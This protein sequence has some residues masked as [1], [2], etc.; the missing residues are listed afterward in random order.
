VPP[1]SCLENWVEAAVLNGERVCLEP[2]RV[3]HAEE[4]APVLE[5]PLLHIFLGGEPADRD[6]LRARYRRQVVGRSPDG[7]QRW[8][9]W[10]CAGARMHSRS[11]R[12]KPPSARTR[13]G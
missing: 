11:A 4:L 10:W 5:D 7:S 3:E 6:Q 12:S 1:V 9:N 8:L 2:L 13:M